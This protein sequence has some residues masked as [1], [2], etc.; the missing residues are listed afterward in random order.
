LGTCLD[1]CTKSGLKE[2]VERI[3]DLN[4]FADTFLTHWLNNMSEDW[5]MKQIFYLGFKNS[6]EENVKVIFV[7]CYLDGNDGIFIKHIHILIGWTLRFTLPIMNP[8][9]ILRWKA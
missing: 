9:G 8:G 2:A 6:K 3:G 1:A 4:S 5:I 7:P